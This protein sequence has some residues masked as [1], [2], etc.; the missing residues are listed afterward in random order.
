MREKYSFKIGFLK[1]LKYFAIF[2]L[3]LFV[4]KFIIAFPELA[5][6]SLGSALVMVA[7]YFKMKSKV[8]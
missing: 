5:Q 3:P 2:V 1:G 8:V 4:D 7:N 6:V